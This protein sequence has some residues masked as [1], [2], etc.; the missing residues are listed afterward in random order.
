MKQ[1]LAA[2][3]F[4]LNAE[5]IAWV[6]DTLASLSTEDRLRQLFCLITYSDDAEELRRLAEQVR[7]GGVMSR[8]VPAE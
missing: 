6:E 3:P 2:D 4:R 7:P 8:P 5:Q 1:Q